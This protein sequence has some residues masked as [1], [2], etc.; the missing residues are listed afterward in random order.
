MAVALCLVDN[1]T[2]LGADDNLLRTHLM[3]GEILYLDSI[4]VAKTAMNGD[5]CEVDATYFHALHQFTAEVQACRWGCN[6]TLMLGIDSLETLHIL[7]CSRTLVDNITGQWS[8]A[9]GKQLALELIM[10]TVV[11]ETECTSATGGIVD[12]LCYHWAVF[13]KEELVADTDLTCGLYQDIPQTE[14]GIELAKQEH[15]DLGISLLLSAIKTGWEHL[16]IVEHKHVVLVEIVENITEVEID[17]LSLLV[18]HLLAI[19]VFLRHLD[20]AALAVDN[21]QATFVTMI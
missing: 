19:L 4:E 12:N 7:F 8:L 10:R 14:L 17:G 13:L 1:L 9:K 16:S 11:K 2:G 6:R 5:E 3:L 18:F 21:H 20:L 15:L